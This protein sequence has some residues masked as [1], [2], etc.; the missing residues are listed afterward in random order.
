MLTSTKSP[1]VMVPAATSYPAMMVMPV[2]PVATMIPWPM[3]SRERLV[4]LCTA[5]RSYC[6]RET[7]KRCASC[8][9]LPKYLTVS[10]KVI[11]A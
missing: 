1:M 6:R 10:T 3:L 2:S 4:L 8:I 9:S 7:S 11:A 5:A